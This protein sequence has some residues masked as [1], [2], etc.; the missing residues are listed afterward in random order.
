MAAIFGIFFTILTASA[1]ATTIDREVSFPNGRMAVIKETIKGDELHSWV[2]R[3]DRAKKL[4][5]LIKAKSAEFQ[6][7]KGDPRSGG[8]L[9]P[10]SN[11]GK[12]TTAYEARLSPGLY[13]VI[14]TPAYGTED[15]ELTIMQYP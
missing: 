10:N 14:V 6:V 4:G 11:H 3:L 8:K 7:W 5:A 1:D 15:Y 13:R 9:M 2:V 12:T